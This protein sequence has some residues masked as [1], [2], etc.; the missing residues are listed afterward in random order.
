MSRSATTRSSW[1]TSPR[2]GIC[3]CSQAFEHHV[4]F[5]QENF[6]GEPFSLNSRQSGVEA[7][8]D[9]HSEERQGLSYV[10]WAKG[11]DQVISVRQQP[12]PH[13]PGVSGP[14]AGA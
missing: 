12:E 2:F 11:S 1:I 14:D 6:I 7:A 4:E 8:V 13:A 9:N 10:A 3:R 5:V